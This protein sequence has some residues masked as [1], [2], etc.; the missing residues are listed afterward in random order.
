V[1][2]ISDG[3]DR[4]S[5]Y[6]FE[7]LAK[8]LRQTRVQVF[9]IGMIDELDKEAGFIRTSQ[10]DK[11][12]KLLT[13]VAQESFGRVFFPRDNS[14]LQIAAEEIANNLHTQFY[15]GFNPTNQKPGQHSVDVKL[16]RPGEKLTLVTRTRYVI[17]R[18]NEK[19]KP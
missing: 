3:E 19:Q 5:Y 11:A 8:L 9:V 13:N 14:E 1:V 18:P 6:K 4:N 2:L 17:E 12:Q 16:T 7:D 15:I 10:R